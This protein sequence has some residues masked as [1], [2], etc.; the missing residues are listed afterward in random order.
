MI[1]YSDDL[2]R[3]LALMFRIERE[4]VWK[5]AAP[6]GKRGYASK[7]QVLCR[8]L[9]RTA[10]KTS[11]MALRLPSSQ[12][13]TYGHARRWS[14]AITP[15]RI[16]ANRPRY[17]RAHYKAPMSRSDCAFSGDY[18]YTIL[19]HALDEPFGRLSAAVSY[20]HKIVSS[21]WPRQTCAG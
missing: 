21:I 7:Q 3:L 9:R 8:V 10:D 17:E 6:R 18:Y 15:P 11:S 12:N 16:D 5:N 20:N 2:Q 4:E 14:H 13:R 19:R 1:G